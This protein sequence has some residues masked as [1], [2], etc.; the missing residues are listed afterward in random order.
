MSAHSSPLWLRF[1]W[2]RADLFLECNQCGAE[3]NRAVKF[4]GEGLPVVIKPFDKWAT[5]DMMNTATKCCKF[6]LEPPRSLF[7]EF[8][9][10]QVCPSTKLLKFLTT[11]LR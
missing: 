3:R 10:I 1:L 7:G 5:P 6:V 11:K 4:G 8:D 9:S 2:S